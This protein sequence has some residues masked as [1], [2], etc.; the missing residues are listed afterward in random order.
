MFFRNFV[1]GAFFTSRF[2]PTISRIV[3]DC[4][5]DRLKKQAKDKC[6]L[7]FAYGGV[8]LCEIGRMGQFSVTMKW[9]GEFAKTGK[10]KKKKRVVLPS[11]DLS[12]KLV[13]VPVVVQTVNKPFKDSEDWEFTS[14]VKLLDN[15][16][17]FN[18]VSRCKSGFFMQVTTLGHKSKDFASQVQN[19]QRCTNNLNFPEPTASTVIPTTMRHRMTLQQLNEVYSRYPTLS[20][21]NSRLS[22]DSPFTPNDL[23]HLPSSDP[24]VFVLVFVSVNR[25]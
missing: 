9:V 2:Q 19:A 8:K 24:Q 11:G 20:Q 25:G 18:D 3:I 22:V 10:G 1:C 14:P 21:W 12:Q 4:G 13:Q 6:N 15:V 23:S 5:P 16:T 17:V 7:N